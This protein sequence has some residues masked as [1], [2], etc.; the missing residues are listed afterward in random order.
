MILIH[1]EPAVNDMLM[2]S[3]CLPEIISRAK[4][5]I[6]TCE[7]QLLGLFSRTFP[8]IEIVPSSVSPACDVQ[9][10]LGR[11]PQLLG[12]TAGDFQRCR[13][14]LIAEERHVSCWQEHFQQQGSG[15]RIGLLWRGRHKVHVQSGTSRAPAVEHW[16]PLTSTSGVQFISLLPDAAADEISSLCGGRWTPVTLPPGED[17]EVLAAQLAAMDL[18]I[19]I[20][21]LM[22]HLAA[23]LGKEVWLL[24]PFAW[25]WHWPLHAETPPWY[26][27]IRLFRPKRLNAWPE[28]MARVGQRLSE[29]LQAN[30]AGRLAG[31]RQPNRPHSLSIAPGRNAG[32]MLTMRQ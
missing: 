21:D 6:L 20:D 28:M 17:L 16:R 18:V 3:A 13:V 8:A 4:R 23:S 10:P 12:Y 2:F 31:H 1:G 11:L 26:S 27:S 30:D 22:A 15:P 14:P 25:G 19:T 5:T 24:L 32:S 9:I 29:W 7:E